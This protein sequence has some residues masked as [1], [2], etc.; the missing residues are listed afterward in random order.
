MNRRQFVASA[1]LAAAPSFAMAKK[2]EPTWDSLKTHPVPDWFH[3]AKLGIFIHWGLYSVPAFAP[4]TGELG[5]VDWNTWFYKNPYAE[6]YLNSL[7]LDTSDTYKHH[8]A[9]YGKDFDY[10]RFAE[11]FLKES[12][13]WDP[14]KWADVIQRTGAGYAV[15]TTKHHDGFTLWP[16]KVRNPKREGLNSKRDF[17]G[18]LT[19][20]VRK[21]GVRMGLYYS[22]GLDWTFESKPVAKMADLMTTAPKSQE[23][24]DYADAHWR[25]LMDRYEPAVLWNDIGYP[26]VGKIAEIFADYYNRFPDGLVNSRFNTPHIDFTT[27]E[28]TKYD[29]IVEKKWETCRGLGFSFGYNKEEDGRHVIASDKLIELLVDIVSKNGNL[30]IN[31]G[32]RPDGGIPEI[33]MDR[34]EKL[35]AW[36]AVNGEGI[37]GTRPHAVPSAKTATGE[38]IRFTRKGETLYAFVLQRPASGVVE[39]PGVRGTKVEL[40]GHKGAA[41]QSKPGPGDGIA[42]TL[43]PPGS[44]PFAFCFRITG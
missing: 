15:L 34:L 20:A 38:E 22:G 19:A 3:D 36:M 39:I 24:A 23:Y 14:G 43:P 6:W 41:L 9:K 26:K 33:Q 12:A 40:L 44:S 18:E 8:A 17:V 13:R 10:Y 7:R 11:T 5:K 27:P 29:K 28:Y 42:V 35:G 31:I 37:R 4:P 30:L 16:S 25:E 2:Y 1:A 21:T 32:P